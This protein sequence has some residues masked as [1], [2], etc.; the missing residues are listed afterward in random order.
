MEC[1]RCIEWQRLGFSATCPSCDAIKLKEVNAKKPTAYILVYRDTGEVAG[2]DMGD[3]GFP[4]RAANESQFN[5]WYDK[6]KAIDYIR[7]FPQ[8][9]LRIFGWNKYRCGQGRGDI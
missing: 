1:P 7:L 4:F 6:D 5:F 9:E 3:S 8:L 2:I